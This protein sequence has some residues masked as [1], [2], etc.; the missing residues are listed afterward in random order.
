MLCTERLRKLLRWTGTCAGS[1]TRRTMGWEKKEIGRKR[2]V[3]VE[4]V[5][6]D[7]QERQVLPANALPSLYH[8][9]PR[10]EAVAKQPLF[11]RPK[12]SQAPA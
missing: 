4:G 8:P 6:R 7:G 3:G 10:R 11:G 2:D 5:G 1:A 12:Y 9:T